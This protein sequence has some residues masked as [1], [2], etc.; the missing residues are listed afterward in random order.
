MKVRI[1]KKKI[2]FNDELEESNFFEKNEGKT[3]TITIEKSHRTLTQN[4]YMWVYLTVI[5]RETGND[6]NELHEFF[7][8]SFLPSVIVKIKGKN[9]THDFTRKKSTTELNKLEF[10][11]YLDRVC[12]Y[13]EI[14][15]PDPQEAGY[16]P[17]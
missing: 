1:G 3:A 2:L 10:G 12:A 8:A 7:K 14:P 11:D 15:L 17:R 13:T 4:A 5:A 9:S 16:L 6:V